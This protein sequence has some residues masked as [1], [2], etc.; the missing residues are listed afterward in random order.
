MIIINVDMRVYVM[1]IIRPV[2]A[3]VNHSIRI[4]F[5]TLSLT[6]SLLVFLYSFLQY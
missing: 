5:L 4:H 3:P 6:Y 1:T 2:S